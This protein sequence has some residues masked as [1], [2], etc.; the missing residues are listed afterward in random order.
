MNALEV[1][2]KRIQDGLHCKYSDIQISTLVGIENTSILLRISLD[3][4]EDWQNNIL[5]NSRYAMFHIG[6]DGKMECFSKH[7]IL[8]TF[9][10]CSVSTEEDIISKINKWIDRYLGEK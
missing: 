10:K 8:P 9:R 2:L 1:N 5:H 6:S 3:K 7:Y 4:K